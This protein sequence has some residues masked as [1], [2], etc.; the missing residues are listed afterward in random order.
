MSVI[1]RHPG[2]PVTYP[3]TIFL[4][5]FLLFIIQPVI[6]KQLLPLFG[7]GSSVWTTLMLFFTTTLFLGYLYVAILSRLSFHRQKLL[8]LIL[9]TTCV[10]TA[11]GALLISFTGNTLALSLPVELSVLFTAF[12]RI[13]L[14][15]F[16]LS[17]TSS[18]IQFWS[19]SNTKAGNPF[20][21]YALSNAGALAGLILYPFIIEPL[22][23]LRFQKMIWY[24]LFIVWSL[25]LTHITLKVVPKEMAAKTSSFRFSWFSLSFVS[26]LM[27][28]AVTVSITQAISPVPFLWL[29]PIGLYLLSYII[30]FSGLKWYSREFHATLLICTLL[31]N[32]LVYANVFYLPYF[33]SV[34]LSLITLFLLC[35]VAHAELYDSRPKAVSLTIFYLMISLG[36]VVAAIFCT[37]VA[38]FIF[39]ELLEFPFGIFLGMIV[40]FFVMIRLPK[41]LLQ[42]IQLGLFCLLCISGF[43]YVLKQQKLNLSK[44]SS[45]TTLEAKR[46]FYGITSIREFS[47]NN[48]PS[49]IRQM[50][51]G[52][53]VH[54]YQVFTKEKEFEPTSYYTKE[55]GVGQAILTH[56]LRLANQPMRVGV[57]GLGVGTLAA[58]CQPKDE[59]TFYE[60]NPDVV[61]MSQKYFTF[62]KHCKSLGGAINI[63]V[64]DARLALTNQPPQQFDVL[65]IDAFTDDA[66]PTHLLTKEALLLYKSHLSDSGIIALHLTNAHLNLRPTVLVTAANIGLKMYSFETKDSRWVLLSKNALSFGNAESIDNLSQSIRPWT[67]DYSNVLQALIYHL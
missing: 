35:L 28:F 25:L 32:G 36:S 53:I 21:L 64:N 20:S 60:I 4:S 19:P 49:P 66:I 6:G 7:G 52:N 11:S 27:L 39:T 58:Y 2:L 55:S 3:L 9:I 54:G 8:H 31:I 37:I 59:Y 67:D 22:V 61:A 38:P 40:V 30:A 15:F 47:N 65:V 50:R 34:I 12:V 29:L 42:K 48:N 33:P 5:S 18:L 51:S 63:I 46:N 17:S 1:T 10:L 43:I 57:V 23:S 24:L 16:L 44:R 56:P 14:P 26:N 13:G 62:L 41:P 45:F